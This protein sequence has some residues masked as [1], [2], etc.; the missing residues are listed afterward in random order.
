MKLNK[1]IR[2]LPIIMIAVAMLLLLLNKSEQI[3]FNIKI[4]IFILLLFAF[5]LDLYFDV[6]SRQYSTA[7]FIII[8]DVIEVIA[9]IALCYLNFKSIDKANIELLW[10]RSKNIRLVCL[11]L[12][13]MQFIK[14][15]LK[16]QRFEKNINS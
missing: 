14:N 2:N 15:I 12:V 8:T 6:K 7:K 4:T 1:V 10:E 9:F 13:L 11:V 3:N 16:S 5:L